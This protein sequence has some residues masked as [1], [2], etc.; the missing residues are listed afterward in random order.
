[1][2]MRK[3]TSVE[4][5]RAGGAALWLWGMRWRRVRVLRAAVCR[6]PPRHGSGGPTSIV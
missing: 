4:V 3:R 2:K 6:P 5:V 1:M